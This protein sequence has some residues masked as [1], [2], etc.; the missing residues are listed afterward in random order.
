M[1]GSGMFVVNTPFGTEAECA[2]LDALFAAL[3]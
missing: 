1:I 3:S 2:R